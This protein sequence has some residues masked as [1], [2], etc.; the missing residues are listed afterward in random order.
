L[1][2]NSRILRLVRVG[3]V[4]ALFLVSVNTCYGPPQFWQ[5]YVGWNE[6]DVIARLGKPDH[7]SRKF[8]PDEAGKGFSL[9]W[10]HGVGGAYLSMAFD[11][12]GK[13]V[14]QQRDAK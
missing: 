14:N 8:H 5:N 9:G 13:V 6:P 1:T 3:V 4:A 12:S 2:R 11:A 7:D 10:Y